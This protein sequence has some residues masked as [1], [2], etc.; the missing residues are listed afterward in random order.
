M[1]DTPL[2]P[3]TFSMALRRSRLP[4]QP[5]PESQI[6]IN[7]AKGRAQL[8]RGS[9]RDTT[10]GQPMPPSAVQAAAVELTEFEKLAARLNIPEGEW[11]KS[12]ALRRFARKHASHRYVPESLLDKWGITVEDSILG[13]LKAGLA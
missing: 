3:L 1:G 10:Y 7:P 9:K 5:R 13:V 12:E 8:R 4:R 2:R 6:V 11:E